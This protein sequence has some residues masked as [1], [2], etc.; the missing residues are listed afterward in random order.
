MQ[1]SKIQNIHFEMAKQKCLMTEII[2]LAIDDKLGYLNE[3][4]C[5]LEDHFPKHSPDDVMRE[6]DQLES[7]RSWLVN[8]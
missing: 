2:T 4:L 3:V 7:A 6:I 1:A 5:E 8:Q